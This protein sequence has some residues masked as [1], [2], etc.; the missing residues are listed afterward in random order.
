MQ[1]APATFQAWAEGIIAAC[2]VISAAIFFGKRLHSGEDLERRMLMMEK[3]QVTS[4]KIL[5]RMGTSMALLNRSIK[6]L[7]RFIEHCPAFCGDEAM[8]HA[9]RHR[10]LTDA[11]ISED[12]IPIFEALGKDDS[13][14][15]LEAGMRKIE[16]DLKG[17]EA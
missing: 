1:V 13:S 5:G 17:G 11:D 14:D 6:S 7:N 3:S 10:R 16:E 9:M 2:G 12:V 4:M 15:D 8:A